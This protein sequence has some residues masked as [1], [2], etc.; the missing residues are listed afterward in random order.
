VR[1]EALARTVCVRVHWEG[2]MLR[3]IAQGGG[4]VRV[5]FTMQ[6]RWEMVNKEAPSLQRAHNARF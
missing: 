2:D 6:E 1:E 5:A 4:Q 3:P